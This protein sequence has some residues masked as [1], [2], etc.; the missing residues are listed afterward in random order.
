MIR[1]SL[2]MWF[3]VFLCML[4]P[5]LSTATY[6]EPVSSFIPTVIPDATAY[7]TY[8]MASFMLPVPTQLVRTIQKSPRWISGVKGSFRYAI[9]GIKANCIDDDGDWWT[10]AVDP[11]KPW[12][13]C[14]DLVHNNPSCSDLYSSPPAES[15]VEQLT[16]SPD[17]YCDEDS[18]IQ[19]T[20]DVDGVGDVGLF[21]TK[22]NGL[23][24]DVNN[25][26]PSE[27]HLIYGTM[28]SGGD[29]DPIG[30]HLRVFGSGGSQTAGDEG[31]TVARLAASETYG[32]AEGTLTGA[33]SLNLPNDYPNWVPGGMYGPDALP[34]KKLIFTDPLSEFESQFAGIGKLI[35][36]SGDAVSL[37]GSTVNRPPGLREVDSSYLP[38]QN[39]ADRVTQ[40]YNWTMQA[41]LPSNIN[42]GTW[43][44]SDSANDVEIAGV[45]R[46]YW[47]MISDINPLDRTQF[48]TEWF[49]Q[50]TDY[51]Y[52]EKI[53][54]SG[55]LSF[56]P[57]A[58]IVDVQTNGEGRTTN[59][60]VHNVG[61]NLPAISNGTAFEIPHYG[62]WSV[63]GTRYVAN[64]AYGNR[65]SGVEVLNTLGS[66]GRLQMKSA[67]EA[68]YTGVV[69]SDPAISDLDDYTFGAWENG[70][71][72][73]PGAATN[74]V[75]YHYLNMNQASGNKAIRIKPPSTDSNWGDGNSNYLTF[76][77]V[78][79]SGV[80]WDI[81]LNRDKGW[82]IGDSLPIVA[83][84]DT[85][86]I[87]S[88]DTLEYD[89]QNW[90]PTAPS[91]GVTWS[92]QICSTNCK[93][94]QWNTYVL[95]T[96]SGIT[97]QTPTAAGSTGDKIVIIG[98]SGSITI[99]PD[100]TNP[101]AGTQT[102]TLNGV[103]TNSTFNIGSLYSTYEVTVF[104]QSTSAMYGGR[105][106][107]P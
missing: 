33:A 54:Y 44:V 79:E 61:S 45:L 91:S 8:P 53:F 69:N 24:V 60:I 67:F 89:G 9:E 75:N 39:I 62:E 26:T 78:E 11:N 95:A 20:A 51:K 56:A 46:S 92:E 7:T 64:R 18:G 19:K 57:C 32:Y 93:V 65:G 82:M 31:V 35:V 101:A 4:F 15:G 29:T 107:T 77:D 97:I 17:G 86:G 49:G 87:N 38:A 73:P 52:P 88:G 48:D 42:A 28:I 96:A 41:D 84:D 102:A 6:K 13:M 30:L 90:V 16:G 106:S 80:N 70:L 58:K 27:S 59:V 83:I 71:Y 105:V 2:S 5:M 99:D 74:G 63:A 40:D 10:D 47:L 81:R 55:N 22:T 98:F 43:C 21:K 94:S 25:L 34:M 68:G 103:Q 72:M 12:F 100:T 76:V 66:G 23:I 85:A 104:S 1:K 50:S 14:P 37:S 3:L 36:V